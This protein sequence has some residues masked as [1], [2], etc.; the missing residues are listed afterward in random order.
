MDNFGVIFQVLTAYEMKFKKI[1]FL[2]WCIFNGVSFILAIWVIGEVIASG[3]STINIAILIANI[4]IGT[5]LGIKWYYD[6]ISIQ[7]KL[8]RLKELENERI[9]T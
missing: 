2:L 7:K 1:L 9:V 5:P 8:V 6:W 4:V 3:K